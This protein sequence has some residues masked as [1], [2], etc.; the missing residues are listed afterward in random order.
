VLASDVAH[1]PSEKIRGIFDMI[2]GVCFVGHS[3]FPG[4]VTP[5]FRW[6]RP[7]DADGLDVSRGKYVVNEGS[8][9]QPRDR[10]PRACYV[11][12]NDGAI[13]FHRVEYPFHTTMQKIEEAGCFHPLS[14]TRLA[15]GR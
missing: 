13:F 4:V 10:D 2:E 14:A 12:W 11:E 6:L 15:E 8:V 3:H 9:G 7:S 5:E 1:G